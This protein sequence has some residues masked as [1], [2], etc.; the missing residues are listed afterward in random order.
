MTV[1]C[2]RYPHSSTMVGEALAYKTGVPAKGQ[3]DL[4]IDRFLNSPITTVLIEGEDN[5]KKTALVTAVIFALT[6]C[7]SKFSGLD[8]SKCGYREKPFN[9]FA[10]CLTK[11]MQKKEVQ[12]S[13]RR[14]I[15]FSN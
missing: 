10:N 8:S 11:E 6:G 12:T 1:L 14:T 4:F 9:V 13:M 2:G 15:V 3:R 5:M 7:A